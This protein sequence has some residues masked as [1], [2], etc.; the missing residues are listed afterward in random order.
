MIQPQVKCAILPRSAGIRHELANRSLDSILACGC[1]SLKWRSVQHGQGWYMKVVILG[2]G[3]IG[4]SAAY[5]LA[6]AGAEVEVVD[7]C[8]G[9]AL[10]TSFAN[11]GQVSPGYS[12]PWAAPGIPLKALKW[13]FQRHAPLCIRPDGS[14]RQLR[15]LASMLAQCSSANYAL[16]KQRMMLLAEYSRDVLRHLRD[17]AKLSYEQRSLGTLQLFR[18]Q[19]QLDAAA[20]DVA[21]LGE[22]GVPFELL[23]RDKL[24]RAEPALGRVK[25][26]LS[27]GLRLP[28]DETGDC[29]LFT[30]QLAQ[31]AAALGVQFLFDT[32]I[33]GI[34]VEAGRFAAVRLKDGQ[35]QRADRCIVAL[36]SHSPAMLQPV[37]ID[38][39]VYPVKGYSLTL[40][41]DANAPV[42]TVLDETYKV[43][44]T[45]FDRR[46][47][48]GGMAELTG[49]D[50]SLREGARR[51]LQMVA[52][53]LFPG[54]GEI[55]RGEFW[56]GLRP[57]TPDGTPVVGATPV[58]GLFINTGHGTL[59]WTMAAGSGRLIAD[60]VTGRKPDIDPDGF[61]IDRYAPSPRPQW[62]QR[63]AT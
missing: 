52:E 2:G 53:D 25:E 26:R 35:R 50:L 17:E 61:G 7:R 31:A 27:G 12:T 40:R 13:L 36:G 43:A 37:G 48:V 1:S 22:L 24:A 21:V 30:Q 15:W 19:A 59:G 55:A 60:L 9:P 51:T 23:G 14:L 18:S 49:F 54:A 39:P 56:T 3:V 29:H 28:N 38:L 6:L 58:Q 34:E 62:R 42:S 11:A 16:N 63:L 41:D 32:A 10:E 57:M 20:R 45:R 8:G 44:V 46:I 5:H 47:R 33:D 4:V